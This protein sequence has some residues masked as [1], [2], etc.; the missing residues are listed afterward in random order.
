MNKMLLCPGSL[1]T[2]KKQ[3]GSHYD[4]ITWTEIVERVKEPSSKPKGDADFFVASTYREHDGRSHD[5]QRTRGA[6]RALCLDV[7][8]GN[9]SKAMLIEAVNR[10]LG[11]CT[12]I[13]YSSSSAEQKNKKWRALIPLADPLTGDVYEEYQSAFFELL[14][15]LGV[16][17][18]S[19]LA[20][21]GQPI[22]LPNIPLERRNQDGSP[23]F[24][25]FEIVRVKKKPNL[26]LVYAE[27]ERRKEQRRQAAESALLARTEREAR[28]RE[29]MQGREDVDLIGH[30]NAAH[31]IADLLSRYQYEQ[32]GSSPH[33]R[34]R[35]Q[36]SGSYATQDFETHWVSLSGSDASAGLGRNKSLGDTSYC[37]GDA[38][39]LYVHFEHIGDFDK[40]L[41]AYADE[42][43][44]P[45]EEFKIPESGLDDFDYVS[46]APETIPDI[47]VDPPEPPKEWP[48]PL[49]MF[50][51]SLLPRREFVYGYDYIRRYVSVVASAGGIGKTSLVCVEAAAICTGKPL[52]GTRVHEPTNVWII[53][54]EDPVV[55]LQMRMLAVLQHYK[56]D[57]EEVRGKIFMDGE[58]TMSMT[59]AVEGRDGVLKNDALL[60]LMIEK[61][62]RD[63]IGVIM[64]DPF[65]ST[66]MVNENANSSI[67][68][69]V[70]M[71]RKLARD[72]NAAV[73]LIHH[74]RKSN[75]DESSID[76][77]RGA[78][79]LIGA[80]RA[81][82]VINRISPE[83]AIRLG[84]PEES[85]KGIMRIDD[86]KSNL[87]PP[88]EVAVYRRMIGVQIENGEYV[89]V[90]VPFE[91]PDAFEGISAKDARKVQDVVAGAEANEKP[92][93]EN[94]QSREWVGYAIGETLNIDA[95][96]DTGKNRVKAILRQ[97]LKTKVLRVHK[98]FDSKKGREVAVVL[99]GEWV[100]YEDIS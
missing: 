94:V 21:C 40:A 33:W 30:F 53:N 95:S 88:A 74:V 93:R 99:V 91:M 18:D 14:H 90:C 34:S 85:S 70:A 46:D 79:A 81:A 92:Y 38:F 5:A 20:R 58:D 82:R 1:Y 31:S 64:I 3:V 49:T 75:G 23:L 41:K 98:E 9:P 78:G 39:D 28:R 97:W 100:T 10:I 66:H 37:W 71:V 52:L 63:N 55:E 47:D 36:S 77:V 4:G 6:F 51:S 45:P 8:H 54:L 11:E 76:S 32:R 43:K 42:I 65:I 60:E 83:E 26:S 96:E 7:D 19:A 87:A 84:V 2:L 86:G 69:V 56:I 35:Y 57:P 15:P 27:V 44:P 25:D 17:P 61:V 29:K 62:R 13:V 12:M 16:H 68:A 72:G 89:G 80:A 48:T 50:D 24:Y 67:Q 59:L 22:Y 73:S